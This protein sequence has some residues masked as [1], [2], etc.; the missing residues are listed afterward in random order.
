MLVWAT[1]ETRPPKNG[2]NQF[3]KM[4]PHLITMNYLLLKSLSIHC[5][6][7]PSILCQKLGENR[8][9]NSQSFQC[10]CCMRGGGDVTIFF[11]LAGHSFRD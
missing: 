8:R 9:G 5:E 6:S 10:R 4:M 2:G 3:I 11:S 1:G 7:N